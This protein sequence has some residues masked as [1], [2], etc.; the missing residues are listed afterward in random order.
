MLKLVKEV[1]HS[2]FSC[3]FETW[4]VI[5][6]LDRFFLNEWHKKITQ[7]HQERVESGLVLSFMC[8]VF[9][10]S[11]DVSKWMWLMCDG[12][13]DRNI[14][15]RKQTIRKGR[16]QKET[17]TKHHNYMSATD[18]FSADWWL[19]LEAQKYFGTMLIFHLLSCPP[20][21]SNPLYLFVFCP[22]GILGSPSQEDLNC[23]INIKA[24]NY[25]LSLPLRCKVPWNRLF[26][27]ADP[28]GQSSALHAFS[29]GN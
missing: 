7:Q 27:N 15:K 21:Y 8:G 2:Y 28:K 5:G 10:L 17:D 20:P 25:L 14:R 24:R 18:L 23:I 4:Y 12:T 11:G 19:R 9:F 1:T 26:P 16:E 29:K 6:A 13:N 22:A 3:V